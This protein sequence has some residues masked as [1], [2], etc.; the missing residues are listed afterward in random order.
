MREVHE[1]ILLQ[2]K[3]QKEQSSWRVSDENAI[4]M[5]FPLS[6]LIEMLLVTE[7]SLNKGSESFHVVNKFIYLSQSLECAAFRHSQSQIE[8]IS[9]S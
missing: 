3:G 1:G 2:R 6:S 4:I 9:I 8:E 7:Q 5:A